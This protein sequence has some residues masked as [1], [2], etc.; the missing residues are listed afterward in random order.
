MT[1]AAVFVEAC[2]FCGEEPEVRNMASGYAG[3]HE[4]H[5]CMWQVHCISDACDVQPDTRSSVS[6]ARALEKWNKRPLARAVPEV[7]VECVENE[8]KRLRDKAY[9]FASTAE[10]RYDYEDTLAD[11]F[12]GNTLLAEADELTSAL[13]ALANPGG[14]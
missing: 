9:K 2:P 14:A 10:L 7:I 13:A 4:S 3:L 5:H 8:V 12:A 11:R 6:R 1:A